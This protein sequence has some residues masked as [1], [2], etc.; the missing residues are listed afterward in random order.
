MN[1]RQWAWDNH[2]EALC[3]EIKSRTFLHLPVCVWCVS[4]LAGS[5]WETGLCTTYPEGTLN[6]EMTDASVHTT[7]LF[8][9]V[10][11]VRI[12]FFSRVEGNV[13]RRG[14]HMGMR[15][16]IISWGDVFHPRSVMCYIPS[17]QSWECK[18]Q[19]GKCPPAWTL[20]SWPSFILWEFQ[21]QT[22]GLI[23]CVWRGTDS[24][25][26]LFSFTK[27]CLVSVLLLL[28]SDPSLFFS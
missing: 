25:L 21:G 23:A 9:Q 10:L 26:G 12:L 8:S 6:T 17:A 28:Y 1:Q 15:I 2:S 11:F 27:H 16:G 5:P 19:A 4:G 13:R 18:W 20:T 7:S 14:Q 3:G 24:S 22:Y